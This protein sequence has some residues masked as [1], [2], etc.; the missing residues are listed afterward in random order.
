MLR[1]AVA[2]TNYATSSNV[3]VLA[4]NKYPMLI[5]LAFVRAI[6]FFNYINYIICYAAFS[7]L[8]SALKF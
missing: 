1:G 4:E 8:V 6:A 3:A 5:R 7:V 2:S